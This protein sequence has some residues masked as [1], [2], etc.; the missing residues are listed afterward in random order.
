MIYK[1]IITVVIMIGIPFLALVITALI[2]LLSQ[3]LKD[4]YTMNKHL[5]IALNIINKIV[6]VIAS[7]IVGCVAV[8]ILLGMY[9]AVY[10]AIWK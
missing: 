8:I 5:K 10:E 6:S 4:T 9:L 7:I 1:G 2:M 3:Y